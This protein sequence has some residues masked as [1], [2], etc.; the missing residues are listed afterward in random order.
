MCDPHTKKGCGQIASTS[1]NARTC[2]GTWPRT[3]QA[4]VHAATVYVSNRRITPASICSDAVRRHTG[5][6]AKPLRNCWT[7]F[8][9]N[10]TR[11]TCSCL[12]C[13]ITSPPSPVG[14]GVP[15]RMRLYVIRMGLPPKS[16]NTM[17]ESTARR[18]H[19]NNVCKQVPVSP[20]VPI[21][22]G[23]T[24]PVKKREA[25]MKRGEWPRCPG[26]TKVAGPSCDTMCWI[27]T[28]SSAG[29]CHATSEM[30]WRV[31]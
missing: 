15:P 6:R 30:V 21:A 18:G 20:E 29:Q 24:A 27:Q 9:L 13:K 23:C 16:K 25:Y 17:A 10:I 22:S 19:W 1:K 5:V 7:G 14:R 3:R 26:H 4:A 12:A 2:H 11:H 31:T 8:A 28:M